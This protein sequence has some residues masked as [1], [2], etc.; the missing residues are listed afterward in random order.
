MASYSQQTTSES[1]YLSQAA[2]TTNNGTSTSLFVGQ[3][4][5]GGIRRSLVRHPSL[6]A[7]IDVAYAPILSLYS[8]SEALSSDR[9]ITV[10]RVKRNWVQS[11]ATWNIYSTGNIWGTAG[12]MGAADYDSTVLGT[13][14]VS[15]TIAANAELQIPLNTALFREYIN[16]QSTYPGGL[17]VVMV[18]TGTDLWNIH[19]NDS[20]TPGYRPKLSFTYELGGGGIIF[21]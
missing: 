8:V 2:P 10:Y 11:Q 19:S 15:E 5:A 4:G 17:L 12:A 18:E 20:A 14:N 7:S 21:F 6:P 9:A 16:N 1:T 13:V 3:S